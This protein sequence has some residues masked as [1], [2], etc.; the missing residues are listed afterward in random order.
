MSIISENFSPVLDRE[1]MEDWMET[2][3]LRD[4]A[5]SLEYGDILHISGASDKWELRDIP[6]DW[7]TWVATPSP[8][9]HKT[10]VPPIVLDTGDGGMEC[11]DGKHRLGE[12]K[13]RGEKT[14]L[15]YVGEPFKETKYICTKC[16]GTSQG[17]RCSRVVSNQVC[18]GTCT[19]QES[20]GESILDEADIAPSVDLDGINAEI[21]VLTAKYRATLNT[22]I[23]LSPKAVR[24]YPATLVLQTL[25]ARRDAPR[26]T[27]TAFMTDLCALADRHGLM[28]TLE[29]GEQR[30]ST[31]FKNT[32]SINRLRAFYARFGFQRNSGKRNYRPDLSGTMHRHARKLG[33]DYQIP[34]GCQWGLGIVHGDSRVSFWPCSE[35]QFFGIEHEQARERGYITFTQGDAKWRYKMGYIAWTSYPNP[36]EKIAVEDFCLK[37]GLEVKEHTT[38]VDNYDMATQKAAADSARY[39][40]TFDQRRGV[41]SYAGKSEAL[42]EFMERNFWL[43][44]GGQWTGPWPSH[45]N[46]AEKILKRN[47]TSLGDAYDVMHAAG[48]ARI[49]LMPGS[50]GT[51]AVS[52]GETGTLGRKPLTTAQLRELR[53]QA[54]ERGLELYDAT[55]HRVIEARERHIIL[56]T[57]DDGVLKARRVDYFHA[58]DYDGETP[59]HAGLGLHGQNRW[60]YPEGSNTVF[61]WQPADEAAQAAVEIYLA[62]RG[63]TGLRHHTMLDNTPEDDMSAG[64]IGLAAKYRLRAESGENYAQILAHGKTLVNLNAEDGVADF[65]VGGAAW[66]IIFERWGLGCVAPWAEDAEE[67]E[68]QWGEMSYDDHLERYETEWA[69]RASGLPFKAV[70]VEW[71]ESERGEYDGLQWILTTPP[72]AVGES[73]GVT[74]SISLISNTPDARYQTESVRMVAYDALPRETQEDIAGWIAERAEIQALKDY[75]LDNW[76]SHAPGVPFHPFDL[77]DVHAQLHGLVDPIMFAVRDLPVAAITDFRRNPDAR[78]YAGKFQRG[79][80]PPP[81][82]VNGTKFVDGGPRLAA[83]LAAGTATIPTV[84][85]WP[86]LRQDWAAWLRD[87]TNTIH[88]IKGGMYERPEAREARLKSFEAEL[89]LK[90]GLTKSYLTSPDP[91]PFDKEKLTVVERHKWQ[92]LQTKAGMGQKLPKGDGEFHKLVEMAW[93]ADF[94]SVIL[95][96]NVITM[97][98]HVDYAA[99]KAGDIRAAKRVVETLAKPDKLRNI[100]HQHPDA[101]FLPVLAM[102]ASGKNMLPLALAE[103]LSKATGLGVETDIIQINKTFHTNSSGAHRLASIAR[104]DGQA[105]QPTSYVLVDDVVTSG[106]TLAAMRQHVEESGGRVVAITALAAAAYANVVAITAGTLQRL[107]AKFPGAE[108]DTLLKD[109][110]IAPDRTDLTNSQANYVLKFSTVDALRRALEKA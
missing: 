102:E 110:K 81:I 71:E 80:V 21:E 29:A 88:P 6:I 105:A 31:G 19:V 78:I 75:A 91:V 28:I 79:E 7:V 26:G 58:Q 1:Q 49:V 86:L 100:V 64:H 107:Y 23:Y 14:A 87:E 11:L 55:T 106:G 10:W 16:G 61:W 22:N 60:R 35:G 85:M 27:G 13:Y 24:D 92:K 39:R 98:S 53:D 97:K 25:N 103:K 34:N 47:F 108:L 8:R 77:H 51:L 44:P 50:P 57:Y 20:L 63:F 84:D 99:A 12:A 69:R 9:H 82:L 73:V 62:K 70:L 45:Q 41:P 36:E 109:L 32:T 56:G 33:E 72:R 76:G 67:L 52:N 65:Q 5:G 54:T 18:G 95:H 3:A 83:A 96:T 2:M 46:G 68:E 90:Y 40:R 30:G 74:E 48:W 17:P 38:Y 43:G 59:T 93:P 15:C 4:H 104:F 37:H 94:P 101:V 66:R 42:E 89:G